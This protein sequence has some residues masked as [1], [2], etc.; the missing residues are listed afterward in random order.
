MSIINGNLITKLILR[1]LVIIII[2]IQLILAPK[3]LIRW[4]AL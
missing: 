3:G 2:I 4:S 1:S